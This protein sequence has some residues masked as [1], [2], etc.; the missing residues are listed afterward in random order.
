M[1]EKSRPQLLSVTEEIE[2]TIT[3]IDNKLSHLLLPSFQERVD[4]PRLAVGGDVESQTMSSL[5]N[6]LRRLREISDRIEN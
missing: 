3:N 5:R 6:I 1:P 2:C 4:I